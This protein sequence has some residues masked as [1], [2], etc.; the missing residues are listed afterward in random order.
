MSYCTHCGKQLADGEKCT[1]PEAQTVAPKIDI[2]KLLVPAVVVIALVILIIALASGGRKE[3]NMEDYID[4]TFS[5]VNTKGEADLDIDYAAL[6]QFVLD[7]Y[8]VFVL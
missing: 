6:S 1:C 3:V 5:G 7:E 4:V 2:K 8:A